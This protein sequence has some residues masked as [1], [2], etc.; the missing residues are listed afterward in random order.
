MFGDDKSTSLVG[1]DGLTNVFLST[2]MVSSQDLIHA[3]F[4][5]MT[6]NVG[7]AVITVLLT[8]LYFII[9]R[10]LS[11]TPQVATTLPKLRFRKRE[12]IL[13][14]GRKM[15]RRVKLLARPSLEQLGTRRGKESRKKKLVLSLARRF[16]HLKRDKELQWKA[17]EPPPSL[18]EVD[19]Q[20][21][22][23][24]ER[25]PS[26]LMYMLRNVRVLGHFEKPI[27]LELCRF[28]ESVFVPAHSYLFR[29]G[30]PDNSIYVVQSGKILVHIT[31]P[32]GKE[33]CIKEVSQGESVHSL[34]SVMDVL[35]NHPSPYKTVSA[36]AAVD[37]TMLRL[38][39]QAFKIVLEHYPESLVR[40]IQII[41][42]RL[43]RVTFMALHNYLGLS[44][45]LINNDLHID[46]SYLIHHLGM[47]VSPAH[48]ASKTKE[49]RLSSTATE[50]DQ[51]VPVATTTATGPATGVVG[52]TVVSKEGLQR[53]LSGKRRT[54]SSTAGQQMTPG[55]S[56]DSS[57]FAVACSRARVNPSLTEAPNTEDEA[58]KP[59]K[60]VSKR[61]RSHSPTPSPFSPFK[62]SVVQQQKQ[63]KQQQA[64]QMPAEQNL[65][66]C[67]HLHHHHH[68]P[69]L[70]MQQ[71][72]Q[73]CN[74]QQQQ[75]CCANNVATAF[76]ASCK[77]EP[78]IQ[79]HQNF[80]QQQQQQQQMAQP[81]P[82][83]YPIQHHYHYQ[84]TVSHSPYH[85]H[86]NQQHHHHHQQ[87]ST[88]LENMTSAQIFELATQD[89]GK[90]LGLS[91]ISVLKGRCLLRCVRANTMLVR[92]GDQECSLYFLVSG[93]LQVLQQIVGKSSEQRTMYM[94]QPGELVGTLAVLT[95]EPSF[96][97]MRALTDVRFVHIAK[98]DFYSL[99]KVQPTIVLNAG[100][101]VIM[102]MSPFV[103]QID[104][105]L[106]WILIEAGRALYRQGEK[107][108][109]VYIILNGRLRSVIQ[110]PTG[111][112]ELVGEY[113]RGEL[114]GLVEVL[115][116]TD[117]ST[118]LMAVRDTEL[119]QIPDEMLNLIKKKHPQVVTRLIHLLGQRIL[120]SLGNQ[121]RYSALSDQI[122]ID[123][124]NTVGNLA[125]VAMVA[126]NDRVP[127]Q[128]FTLELQNSLNAIGPTLRL[129]SE[130][131]MNKL[132]KGAFDAMNEYR[133][134]SWLGQQEDIH[135][136]VLYECDTTMTPW[137]QRCIRQSDCILVVA[138]ADQDPSVGKLE[139]QLESM[140]V[141]AQKELILLHPMDRTRLKNTLEWLNMRGWCSGHHHIRCPKRVF[142]KKPMSKIL[143]TYRNLSRTEPDRMSDFSRLARFLTGTSIGVVLG[144]GGARGCAHVG[145]I[146]ALTEAGI[147]ID[148]IGG[149]SIGS[150]MGAL[151]ALETKF[152]PFKQTAREFT[153]DMNQ[154]FKKILDLTYPMT[155]MFTGSFLNHDVESVFQ[156]CQIE[157]LWI[158]Y[159][160][161]T[162]DITASKMRVHT[163]GSL[164]R[165]VRASMSLSGYLP[166]L[167]DPIDGHLLLDGGYV[168]NLPADIMKVMGA[169]TIFA[170]DVSSQ[171]EVCLTNYGDE[172]S[173][174]WLL[175]KKF[176]PWAEQ[177][178]VPNMAEIQSRLAYVSC[179]RQMEQVKNSDYCEYIRPPVDK[180]RT[181][182]FGNFE[183]ISDVGYAH[184]K[185]LFS[186]WD[187]TGRVK[188]IFL[189]KKEHSKPKLDRTNVPAEA[190][191]TDLAELISRIEEPDLEPALV[192]SSN[193]L[194]KAYYISEPEDDE[195]VISVTSEP[196]VSLNSPKM[197]SR[198]RSGSEGAS[199]ETQSEQS[200]EEDE[201]DD[202]TV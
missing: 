164:W 156:D 180:Y 175:W 161:I 167:C 53:K 64:F 108:D 10:K 112:K 93:L 46:K 174:W 110:L 57:D 109:C 41:M 168:N 172:L 42:I 159:F 32:D 177:V 120:G 9:R 78:E 169:Q 24:E 158:P 107:S 190:N 133:L 151:W 31:E 115:T 150:F 155:A 118:T 61:A 137:T 81:P 72:Q 195:D 181:M 34:L 91:D 86:H 3:Y 199:P 71:Q 148:I 39:A 171:D 45:E 95:G 187:K 94:A 154:L 176:N 54:E 38:P 77:F 40:V 96:F 157:D 202:D 84:P 141:R 19:L 1:A 126:V 111:K 153:K 114:V 52:N 13:F 139:K 17:R 165:Y 14:Y 22:E 134:S 198:L 178:K 105:A 28:I 48:N 51:P 36:I 50:P 73:S 184:A 145:V 152:T 182:Q 194:V 130:V 49:N 18:L 37:T 123:S 23:H 99:M 5:S 101:T 124:K 146:K 132:G 70:N 183:E 2:I 173:G 106:D 43:Q 60:D 135:R 35:T 193:E 131:V 67:H 92:Q 140:S 44:Q 89:L 15:L 119:A 30:D 121:T 58:S 142:N 201:E 47:K 163:H 160:C 56:V 170:V 33:Y 102:R 4:K 136:M 29:I 66:C 185:L 125:T 147:P 80:Q 144:G 75:Q 7:I 55:D 87:P 6:S 16:L 59:S 166:P 74:L 79:Q 127:L 100:H 8:V 12:K 196:I 68:H 138:L 197:Y 63:N 83:P 90:L 69:H 162:T 117:R 129:N 76:C 26:E 97:S 189:E 21:L 98:N 122:D 113:G 65:I 25:L 104:F 128:T 188:N 62:S 20:E 191:F 143:E 88:G 116:Q 11:T 186:E 179:N 149:T 85:H 192:A 82:P 27:F 200:Q 103:R